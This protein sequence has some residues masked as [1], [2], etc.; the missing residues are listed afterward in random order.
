MYNRVIYIQH[1]TLKKTDVHNKTN[2]TFESF[3]NT[4]IPDK[5]HTKIHHQRITYI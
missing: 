5:Q 2:N 3:P 1:L 4:Q